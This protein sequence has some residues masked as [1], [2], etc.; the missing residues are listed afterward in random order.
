MVYKKISI[1]FS[2]IVIIVIAL[3]FGSQKQ[4][5]GIADDMDSLYKHPF[6]VSNAAKNINFHLVSMHRHMKDVV[7]SQNQEQMEWAVSRVAVHEQA[8]LA[9]FDI[10]FERFLGEKSQI[11]E[12][13]QSFVDW[14]PIRNEVI[15]LMREGK[16][17][18]ASA[19]TV[20]KGASHVAKLN[21]EV[22]ALVAFAYNKAQQFHSSAQ[23]SKEHALFINAGFSTLAVIMVILFSIYV[24]RSLR[25]ANKDR[26]RR[27]HLIDQQ[28]MMATLDKSGKVID[29]SNALCRFLGCMKSDLI[30]KPSHFF[31]NSAQS[32]QLAKDILR[33]VSTGMEWTGEI[34][35]STS[36]HQT[37]W[38][39]SSVL[40]NFDES[41]RIVN[42]TNILN[43]VTNKKLSVVDKLTALP[44]RRSYDD[45]LNKELRL[46][47][48]HDYNITL[49]IIDID[50]F[51]KYNDHYGH[52]QGDIALQRVATKL[53]ECL[54]RPSDYVFR[55][56]GEEFALIFSRATMAESQ[57]FLDKLR[58]SIE[59]LHIE[60]S[61]SSISDYLTISI[62]GYVLMP[63]QMSDPQALYVAADKALYQA[64][65]QRNCA[66]V[67]G[68]VNQ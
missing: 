39:H 34:Q 27:N 58:T 64:K 47:K 28:I 5:N 25:A 35:H 62:G 68:T 15:A 59:F 49:A 26:I 40:P 32:E 19:I 48:R 56:G 9:D 63:P 42:Y 2:A 23:Q 11:K 38:A 60:H 36:E 21:L 43:D 50:F 53:M 55:I 54:K 22:E 33:V 8:A 52:P 4:L 14:Q 31:D 57:L 51:K 16:Q 12:T 17:Q 67:E 30:G 66:V 13:Y 18:Q 45:L 41:Y 24:V 7:L 20:G 61:E 1:G 6:T 29:A 3:A 37:F 65:K 46:A 10:I 44:N